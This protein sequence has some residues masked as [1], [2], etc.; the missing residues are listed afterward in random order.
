MRGTVQDITARKQAEQEK[1]QLLEQ[2][3][4][5]QKMESVG[6]LAGGVAHD[7]NNMLCA[8]TGQVDLALDEPSVTDHLRRLM[9]GV[10]QAAERAAGLTRQLLAFSRKQ[11]IEPRVVDLSELVQRLAPM[12]RRL[13]GEDVV[14]RTVPQPQLGRV[15]VDPGLV[16]QIVLNL[17]VNARDAMPDGGELLIETC[18]VELNAEYCRR[19]TNVSPGA[20][21]MLAVSD[22]GI[23]IHEEIRD[24]IFEPFFTTKRPDQGTGLGLAMVF[25]IV[26]QNQGRIE[27]YSE[28][29]RGTT[30]KV[31]FPQTYEQAESDESRRTGRS[32]DGNETVLL[33]E[34]EPMVRALA[35]EL[36]RSR[37]YEILAVGSGEEALAVAGQHDG[38]IDLLLTDVI[39]PGMNGGELAATLGRQRPQMKVLFT[40]GHTENVI[41]HHGVLYEG[42]EFLSKPY[43]RDSLL[44]R[45]REVLEAPQRSASV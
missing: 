33:V 17:A 4:Q 8:V 36:L 1:E 27:V 43:S 21:V 22:T 15:K 45:V 29:G 13:I 19:Y 26:E 37:G 5:A 31:Y 24:R 42:V 28:P 23:G 20:Y 41:A 9:M 32:L 40:S 34:D 18:N 16:E 12:L 6:R 7:F 3:H 39:M 10:L 38:A 14:L 11:V 35:V 30:F 2:L 44:T 25:G